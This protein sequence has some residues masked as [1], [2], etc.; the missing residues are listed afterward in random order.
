MRRYIVLLLIGSILIQGC[1]KV[2]MYAPNIRK[3]IQIGYEGEKYRGAKNS[4]W[5]VYGIYGLV[6]FNDNSSASLI[7]EYCDKVVIETEYS[8]LNGL[9]EF[10]INIV[11]GLIPIV[12]PIAQM[13]NIPRFREIKVWC[14]VEEKEAKKIEERRAERW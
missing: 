8:V 5:V 9:A 3:D 10:G 4:K 2:H 7:S 6:N 14:I 1:Y 13:L 11:L 12:G